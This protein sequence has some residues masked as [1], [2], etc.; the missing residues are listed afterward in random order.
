MNIILII[1]ASIFSLIAYIVVA[2]CFERILKNRYN[3]YQSD[4]WIDIVVLVWPIGV[5]IL[6]IIIS[7]SFSVITIRRLINCLLDKKGILLRK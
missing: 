6:I 1:L 5:P 2:L 7:I 4:D 3:S